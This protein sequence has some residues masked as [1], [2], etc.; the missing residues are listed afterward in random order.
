MRGPPDPEM[1]KGR[2]AKGSPNSQIR[3]EPHQN[4]QPALDKQE[5]ISGNAGALLAMAARG[6][7]AHP[8]E[9]SAS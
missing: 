8:I 3:N 4:T 9:R 6:Y 7:C 2:L 5:L 1:R